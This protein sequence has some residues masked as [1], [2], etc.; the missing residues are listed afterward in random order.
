MACRPFTIRLMRRGGTLVSLASRYSVMPSGFKKSSASTSPGWIGGMSRRWVALVLRVFI[1]V[2]LCSVIVHDLH[3]I[4]VAVAPREAYPPLIVDADAVLALAVALKGFK[5]IAGRHTQR[6]QHGRRI[7][8][9][10]LAPREALQG[11]RQFSGKV[12]EKEL[13]GVLAPEA[14]DH[15]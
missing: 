1:R 10:Q 9:Q 8:L 6:I 14:L 3:V 11:V 15:G 7:E 12:T 13:F 2:T 5:P 4:G